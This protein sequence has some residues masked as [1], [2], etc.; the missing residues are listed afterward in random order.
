MTLPTPEDISPV[1]IY[2]ASDESIEIN[3]QEFN[4]RDYLD[5]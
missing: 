4:A 3:G 2:L 5:K 1:F